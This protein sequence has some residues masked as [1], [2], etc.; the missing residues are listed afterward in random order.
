MAGNSIAYRQNGWGIPTLILYPFLIRGANGAI[1]VPLYLAINSRAIDIVFIVILVL[2]SCTALAQVPFN[3]IPSWESGDRS[4]VSTG[5]AL[6]DINNDGWLDLVVAN[7]NDMQRQRLVVYYNQH[8]TLPAVPSW[9]SADVDY[10]GHLAIGDVNHDGFPDVAVSV[11]LGPNSF[12]SLGKVKIYMNRNGTLES[13]PSWQSAD[14]MYTF[15]CAFGDANGDGKLDLAVACG[16][17]YTRSFQNNRIYFN[18][19]TVL[20]TTPGWLSDEIGASMCVV[21]GDVDNDG[22]LDLA[23]TNGGNFPNRIYFNNGGSIGK[24][25]GWVSTDNS[26]YG[27]TITFGDV[28]GD[29]F[30]ELG[31]ADNN[32]LGGTGNLKIYRNKGGTLV[33][34]PFWQSYIGYGSS[35]VFA[36]I[37]SDGKN[38]LLAG[39]WWGGCRIYLNKGGTFSTDPDWQSTPKS[40]VEN[41]VLNDIRRVGLK[42][43]LEAHFVSG[44]KVFYLN[45]YPAYAVHHIIVG[46]DTLQ[47]NQ[48]CFDI[49]NGWISLASIPTDTVYV[50]YTYSRHLDLAVS[51]WDDNKGNYLFLNTTTAGVQYIEPLRGYELYQNYPNPFNPATII[52]YVVGGGEYVSIKVYDVLGREVRG[53]VSELKEP[54]RYSVVWDGRDNSGN[55]SASGM[56]FYQL[57]AGTFVKTKTMLLLR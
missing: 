35:I 36:D 56:Y 6:A 23:F 19:G 55:A 43:T 31:V 8:G 34:T 27:N 17:D 30:L 39:S 20:Q 7:G 54:G 46:K 29:G 9:Q 33:T 11:Y 52:E 50:H 41:I 5:A 3:P 37:D 57:R 24:T 51:N 1:R 25:A 10:H 4:S 32:Q 49:T 26:K 42:E 44:K 18:L 21:W 38:D 2:V 14:S 45:H 12:G 13:L 15:R 48:F 28:N 16:D 40:V 53:L 47:L 22:D